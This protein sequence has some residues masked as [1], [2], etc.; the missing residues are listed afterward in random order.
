MARAA[1]RI[2]RWP[3]VMGTTALV[4]AL[5][6]LTAFDYA[7]GRALLA[8]HRVTSFCAEAHAGTRETD[9]IQRSGRSH[10]WFL[11]G[12]DGLRAGAGNSLGEWSCRAPAAGGLLSTD[13]R[14]DRTGF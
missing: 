9:F 5:L 11:R 3:V 13:G 14:V 7:V 8:R 2:V 6:P 1:W 12:A 4:L 10:L